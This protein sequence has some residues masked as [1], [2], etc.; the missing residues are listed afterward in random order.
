MNYYSSPEEMESKLPGLVN[1]L[2]TVLAMTTRD[3]EE[4]AIEPVKRFEDPDNHEWVMKL[5]VTVR[6]RPFPYKLDFTLGELYGKKED[7]VR[8]RRPKRNLE[9]SLD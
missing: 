5:M 1:W 4:L 6:G 8:A 3:V 7:H 9:F 2:W